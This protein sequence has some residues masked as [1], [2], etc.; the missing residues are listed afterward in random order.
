MKCYLSGKMSG[1]PNDNRDAFIDAAKRWRA[2]GY[3]VL[4][5]VELDH[6]GDP[7][8]HNPDN[9]WWYLRRDLDV[10]WREKP[11]VI[12]VLKPY[13]TS[14]GCGMEV[15]MGMRYGARIEVDI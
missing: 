5:P 14:Y 13:D 3:E 6:P 10:I 8:P 2:K 15:M 1:V 11:E 7:D 4:S 9:W 12:V